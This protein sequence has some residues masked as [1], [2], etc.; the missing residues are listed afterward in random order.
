MPSVAHI[1]DAV[2]AAVAEAATTLRPDVAQ[3]LEAAAASGTV[4]PLTTFLRGLY[5]G[6]NAAGLGDEDIAVMQRYIDE[7]VADKAAG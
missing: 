3:A 4:M 2:Y 1:A 5:E 7:Y 6:L